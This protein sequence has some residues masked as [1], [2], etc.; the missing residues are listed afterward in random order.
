MKVNGK[1]ERHRGGQNESKWQ[2]L[3]SCEAVKMKVSGKNERHARR[4]KQV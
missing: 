3:T 2:E 1:N 4:S